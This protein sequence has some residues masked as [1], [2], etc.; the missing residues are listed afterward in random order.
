MIHLQAEI[1][2]RPLKHPATKSAIATNEPPGAQPTIIAWGNTT[3]SCRD[4][5]KGRFVQTTTLSNQ[6]F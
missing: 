6:R 2:P 3:F 4:T 1:V 5:N